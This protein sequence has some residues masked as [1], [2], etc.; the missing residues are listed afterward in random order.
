LQI[1][2]NRRGEGVNLSR[3][4]KKFSTAY[5]VELTK[6]FVGGEEKGKIVARMGGKESWSGNLL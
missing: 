6:G 4:R 2:M 5:T 3:P 1:N